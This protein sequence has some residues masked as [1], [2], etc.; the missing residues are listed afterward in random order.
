MTTLIVLYI[1][2]LQTLPTYKLQLISLSTTNTLK[3]VQSNLITLKK[4]NQ[5]TPVSLLKVFKVDID[6][7]EKMILKAAGDGLV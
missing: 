1:F 2:T 6:S 4:F 3:T 5:P 7:K